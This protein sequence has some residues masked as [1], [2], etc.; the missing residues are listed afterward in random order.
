MV[1]ENSERGNVR[2][3]IEFWTATR[4]KVIDLRKQK[5]EVTQ[6][7]I[8][9]TLLKVHQVFEGPKSSTEPLE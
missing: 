6:E 2:Q 4:V 8:E 7:I 3:V 1:L 5:V 9:S